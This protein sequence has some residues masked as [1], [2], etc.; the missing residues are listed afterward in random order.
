MHVYQE[1][2]Y[3]LDALEECAYKFGLG[4]LERGQK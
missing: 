3:L 4:L 1:G 2:G